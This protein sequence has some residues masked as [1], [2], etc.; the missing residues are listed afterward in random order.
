M[1][2]DRCKTEFRTLV[3]LGE[4]TTAGGWSSTRDRCWANQLALAINAFQ[5]TPVYLVNVGIGANV[6]STLSPSYANSGKPA[7][8]ERLD[9]HVLAHEPDLLIISYG[10]NDARGGTPLDLFCDEMRDILRRVRN[11]IQPLILLL[12]PYYMNDFELG[13]PAFGH[14][15][16]EVFREYNDAIRQVAEQNDCLFVDLLEAYGG[17][18][19][20]VHHDGVHANDMGHRIVANR[21]F[22]VLASNC[23]GLAL[24]TRHL[25][26]QI[27]AWRDESTLRKDYGYDP[28]SARTK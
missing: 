2:R 14:G 6:I 3:T 7:A 15:S 21:I 4:S 25:E 22:E 23:S 16:L 12:G 1:K 24:E 9:K 20:L 19:W 10:L 26:S 13:K 11:A 18:D 27:P 5:R 8:L 28:V 17:A